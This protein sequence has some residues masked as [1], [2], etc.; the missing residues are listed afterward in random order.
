MIALNIQHS[1][2]RL[3]YTYAPITIKQTIMNAIQQQL[4]SYLFKDNKVTEVKLQKLLAV[5]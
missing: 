1:I 2:E 4:L 3:M 5:F